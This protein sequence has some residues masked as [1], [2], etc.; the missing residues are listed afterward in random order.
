MVSGIINDKID[1]FD[2]NT[3]PYHVLPLR[4]SETG[5]NGN[6]GV[7]YI[8]Q[9]FRSY[10]RYSRGKSLILLQRYSRCVLQTP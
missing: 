9:S 6:K 3:R 8:P 10:Q 5:S 7:L 2:P 4:E 1:L